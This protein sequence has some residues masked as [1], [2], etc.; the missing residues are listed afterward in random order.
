MIKLLR[1]L[2]G[3]KAMKLATVLLTSIAGSEIAWHWYTVTVMS[4]QDSLQI[5]AIAAIAV[6]CAVIGWGTEV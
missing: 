5:A 1:F 4:I 6:L 3:V 2:Q